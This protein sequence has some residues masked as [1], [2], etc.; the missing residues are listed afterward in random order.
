ALAV[1]AVTC[2]ICL[3]VG[4]PALTASNARWL[5]AA[6]AYD[7]YLTDTARLMNLSPDREPM[8]ILLGASS[9]RQ[10]MPDESALAEM[11]AADGRPAVKV[12]SLAAPGARSWE[13]IALADRLPAGLRAVIVVALA[14]TTISPATDSLR[15]VISEPR[16]GFVSPAVDGEAVAQGIDVP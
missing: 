5:L 9:L 11:V 6:G 16:F 12:I 13:F 4:L 3:F 1:A 15:E 7:Y 14:P 2:G 10:S 8:V